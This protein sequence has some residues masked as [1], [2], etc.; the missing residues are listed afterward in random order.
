MSTII[1]F[2]IIYVLGLLNGAMLFRP[3]QGSKKTITRALNNRR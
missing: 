3:R 2:V 1:L